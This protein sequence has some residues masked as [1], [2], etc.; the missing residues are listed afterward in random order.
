M[1]DKRGGHSLD[2]TQ[3][4]HNSSSN[5]WF[6]KNSLCLN[7]AHLVHLSFRTWP[8]RHCTT[9][10]ADMECASFYRPPPVDDDDAW[11]G[12]DR[13]GFNCESFSRVLC[14]Q[15]TYNC[16]RRTQLISDLV[17]SR[18]VLYL[19]P[20]EYSLPWKQIHFFCACL[21]SSSSSYTAE[22]T[23]NSLVINLCCLPSIAIYTSYV[24]VIRIHSHSR[25][26]ENIQRSPYRSLSERKNNNN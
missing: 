22:N 17:C 19:L 20:V 10:A 5:K 7:Y 14:T 16:N 26:K 13:G 8:G 3:P 2:S 21:S 6:I 15:R 9:Y 11:T 18:N 24:V 23:R 1:L 12:Q 25:F 4:N